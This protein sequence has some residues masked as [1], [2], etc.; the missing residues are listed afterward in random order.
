M[1]CLGF[2]VRCRDCG[3]AGRP[4]VAAFAVFKAEAVAAHSRIW[5]TLHAIS[6]HAEIISKLVDD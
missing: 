3:E 1:A 5:S 6:K 2:D 4:H